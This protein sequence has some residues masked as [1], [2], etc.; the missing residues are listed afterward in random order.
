MLSL[1]INGAVVILEVKKNFIQ[2]TFDA[3][4]TKVD[5]KIL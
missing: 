3:S 2:G 5:A 4:E 1:Y